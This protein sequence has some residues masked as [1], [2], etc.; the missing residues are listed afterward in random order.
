MADSADAAVS[1][2]DPQSEHA[3]TCS[4][5]EFTRGPLRVRSRR[6]LRRGTCRSRHYFGTQGAHCFANQAGW[7]F[8]HC[9]CP[10]TQCGPGCVCGLLHCSGSSR[11]WHSIVNFRISG[12]KSEN[13][14]NRILIT[15]RQCGQRTDGRTQPSLGR[16]STRHCFQPKRRQMSA[17]SLH[18]RW[19][20]EIQIALPRWRAAMAR[21][22][23]PNT[24]ARAKWLFAGIIDRALHHWGHVAALDG[25]PGEHDLDDSET[26]TA[27]PDEGVVVSP[28]R[29][30]RVN[31]CI[32][33]VSDCPVYPRARWVRLSSDECAPTQRAGPTASQ[34]STPL[35]QSPS[36][37]QF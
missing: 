12:T 7:Y 5:A 24:S 37:E 17:K 26:D 1:F 36:R 16:F 30:T 25:G 32:H 10:R 4:S 15:A 27:I 6:S 20:H 14:G 21:A 19:K 3:E 9:C 34:V 2:P 33:Q 23:L 11:R 13:R 35:R 8:H 28:W 31:L 22:V 29:A 18:R